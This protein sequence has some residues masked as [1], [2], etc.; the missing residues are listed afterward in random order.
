MGGDAKDCARN[1]VT[2]VNPVPEGQEVATE[3]NILKLNPLLHDLLEKEHVTH[4]QE[5]HEL[6]IPFNWVSFPVLPALLEEN[7]EVTQSKTY[8][9][10]ERPRLSPID[11]FLIGS[12]EGFEDDISKFCLQDR[13]VG[14][15][16]QDFDKVQE[17]F[18]SSFHPR[19]IRLTHENLSGFGI[20]RA[21]IEGSSNIHLGLQFLLKR[22]LVQPVVFRTE[23]DQGPR[24]THLKCSNELCVPRLD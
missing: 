2:E 3:A 24:G 18:A 1:E 8:L 19:Q 6:A 13:L 16:V 22:G 23:R 17:S 21:K 14:R 7:R 9:E 5:R 12:P 11:P 15:V 20:R 4:S 10:G